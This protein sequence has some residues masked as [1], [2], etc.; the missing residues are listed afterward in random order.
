MRYREYLRRRYR[1]MLNHAGAIGVIIGLLIASPLLALPFFRDE[2]RLAPA[3]LLPALVIIIAGA[4]LSRIH[5][6]EESAGLT[7]AEGSVIVVI[8]WLAALLFGAVP[9]MLAQNLTFTQAVFEVTSGWTTTGLSVVDV[10]RAPQIILL[11]RSITQLA[12]GAGFAIL[13]LT[14]LAGPQGMGLSAAEGRSDQLEPHVRRSASIVLRLYVGYVIAGIIGLRIAGMNWFDAVNH[15]FAALS[16]GGFSTRA[17]SIGYWDSPLIELAI[18]AL[19]LVGTVNF[20]T[21][22]AILRGGWR[23]LYRTSELRVLYLILAISIPLAYFGVTRHLYPSTIK[24]LRVAAFETISALSTTGF[25]TVSYRPWPDFGWLLIIALMLIGGGSGSTAGGIKQ[26]RIYVLVKSL[27]W[28]IRQPLQPRSIVHEIRVWQ[29]ERRLYIDDRGVRR[30]A[31]FALMHLFVFALGTAA[32]TALGYN[33]AESGFEFAS[34][35]STI[36]LSVGVTAADAHPAALWVMTAG[37]FLGRLE[38]FA[39]FTGAAKLLLDASALLRE[40]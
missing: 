28:H 39:V 33:L 32:L 7:L 12:G 18:I 19:M 17:A 16:T 25:A 20:L 38:F 5:I 14:A 13:M 10:T 21:A 4:L 34:A 35:L 9:F 31:M 30:V 2:A 26:A 1:I 24:A 6:P 8:T 3:F 23:A 15:A 37:M 11:Y 29:G 22:Y 27:W 40:E 36:G